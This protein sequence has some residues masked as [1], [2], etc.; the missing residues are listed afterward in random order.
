LYAWHTSN[1]ESPEVRDTGILN[2]RCLFTR[3]LSI[4][5]YAAYLVLGSLK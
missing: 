2:V 4:E 1:I 5:Y 3:P